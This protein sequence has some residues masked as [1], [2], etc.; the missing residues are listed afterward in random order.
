[1][2]ISAEEK[3]VSEM[4]AEQEGSY[5]TGVGKWVTLQHISDAKPYGD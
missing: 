1:M 3:E 4:E 2:L 5:R